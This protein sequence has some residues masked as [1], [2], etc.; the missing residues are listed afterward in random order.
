ME[1]PAGSLLLALVGEDRLGIA[2]LFA[3]NIDP[4]YVESIKTGWGIV[5]CLLT[6]ERIPRLGDLQLEGLC[7]VVAPDHATY[8]HPNLVLDM[9]AIAGSHSGPR[10]WPVPLRWP[11]A[12]RRAFWHAVGGQRQIA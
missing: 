7:H 11:R 2:E 10:T 6:G 8:T 12:A 3:R 9:Q 5:L 1:G 4:Q